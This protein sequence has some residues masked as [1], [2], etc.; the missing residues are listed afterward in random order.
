VREAS[1]QVTDA[2][3]TALAAAFVSRLNSCRF[4]VGIHEATAS[5]VDPD[6][7]AA[8]LDRW[9]DGDAE[10][11]LAPTFALLEKVTSRPVSSD[12]TTSRASGGEIS[13]RLRPPAAG[14]GQRLA[15][16]AVDH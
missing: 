8:R 1:H 16:L 13:V 3:L 15:R 14:E 4:C 2:D 7:A 10:P 12:L 6:V 5:L 9:R 11:R